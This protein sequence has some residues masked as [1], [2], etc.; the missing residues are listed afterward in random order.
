MTRYLKGLLLAAVF[1]L[2]GLLAACDSEAEQ[3]VPGNSVRIYRTDMGYSELTWEYY[4][5][6]AADIEAEVYEVLD[7][8]KSTPESAVYNKIVP[9]TV[10]VLDYGFGQE[11]QLILNFSE[12]YG[13]MEPL[14]EILCRAGVVKTLC[15]LEGIE[16]VEFLIN[17]QPL[18]L[19]G[20][21]MAGIMSGEDF[22]DN[23]GEDVS[24]RQTVLLTVFYAT[25]DGT[26]LSSVR[27]L[28]ESNGTRSQ[29]ELA[30]EQL[31]GGPAFETS[32]YRATLPSDTKLNKILVRDGI[33]YLDLSE[34]FLNGMEGVT[35]EVSVYSL[36]N[37][38]TEFSAVNKVK[39][40]V[41]STAVKTYGTVPIDGFLE[42]RPDLTDTERAG[43]AGE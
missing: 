7:R 26:T 31:I 40:T 39:I 16:G 6:K 29:E 18:V 5:P 14:Q 32:D 37:T 35:D 38:L 9:D 43:D 3:N 33:C 30:L 20:D 25:G 4:V 13:S 41:D 27:L 12:E 10:E 11:G 2:A 22:I 19:N 28:V 42:R 23:T 1:M 34:E 8:L 17:G 21:M 15:G 24:F 36:V